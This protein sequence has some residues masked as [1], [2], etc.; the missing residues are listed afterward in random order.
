LFS[1][2][3]VAERRD[4]HAAAAVQ[5]RGQRRPAGDGQA[6]RHDRV[7][8]QDAQLRRP[9]VLGS[10]AAQVAAVP[11]AQHLAEG[12][13]QGHPPGQRP[14]VTAVG[15]HHEVVSA[16]REPG[17]D[18]HGLLADAQVD[19]PPDQVGREQLLEALLEGPDDQ[20]QLKDVTQPGH[21][22]GSAACRACRAAGGIGHGY[23][24]FLNCFII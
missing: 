21:A 17:A 1:H 15:G 13:L 16:G 10:A 7:A 8:R 2:R 11:P 20:R 6:G 24:V 5:L 3:P 9:K 4:R 18:G 12:L 14:G 19:G 23:R 22:C